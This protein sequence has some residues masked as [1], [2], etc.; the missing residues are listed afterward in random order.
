MNHLDH[1]WL[2]GETGGRHGT[3]PANFV[4][5]VPPGLPEYENPAAAPTEVSPKGPYC[6]AMYPYVGQEEGDLSFNEG[7]RIELLE[8]KEGDW[9]KGTLNGKTG[10]FPEAYVKVEQGWWEFKKS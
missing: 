8:H 9:L 2:Y 10:V 5:R 3:F 6:T 4:D 7:D 1:V